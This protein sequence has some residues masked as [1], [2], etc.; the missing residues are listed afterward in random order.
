M[1]IRERERERERARYARARRRQPHLYE[2]ERVSEREIEGGRVCT[3]ER[4]GESA[5]RSSLT[6][7]RARANAS[8]QTN[9]GSTGLD[10]YPSIYLCMYVCMYVCMYLSI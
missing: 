1:R 5:C 2:R 4:K 6:S 9:E 8:R 3:R 7:P 10:E